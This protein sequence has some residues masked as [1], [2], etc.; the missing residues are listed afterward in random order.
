L[1]NI[2]VEFWQGKPGKFSNVT[3]EYVDIDGLNHLVI[4]SGSNIVAEYP[5][6][7]VYDVTKKVAPI[8][9]T[10]VVQNA[11]TR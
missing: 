7:T 8:K 1:Y 10:K 11:H 5:E 4:K 3:T 9:R 6:S 2:R